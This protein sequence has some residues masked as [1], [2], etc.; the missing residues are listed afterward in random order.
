[1]RKFLTVSCILIA[2]V[3]V[4][5]CSD[6][7]K[8]YPVDTYNLKPGN[9][10]EGEADWYKSA[11]FYHLWV[12]AFNDAKYE[13]GLGDL[14]GIVKKMDYLEDLGVTAIWLSP[15]F[16]CA[17]KKS[18]IHGYDVTD[19]YSLND[20]FGTKEDL[21]DLIDEA[22]D[23]GIRVIFDFPLNHTST[24]HKWM[25]EH[26]EWYVWSKETPEKWGLPWGGGNPYNVWRFHKN[27]SHFYSAFANDEM[28]DLNYMYKD[29]S[30]R[31]PVRDEMIKTAKY[32]LDRGFDGIRV[33]AARYLVEDGPG[34]QADSA[35]TH[36]FFRELRKS[37]DEY[38]AKTKSPK[39][40]IAEAWTDEPKVGPYFGSGRDEFQICFDFMNAQRTV[41]A[42]Q[43]GDPSLL[44]TLW[45]FERDNY[46]DGYTMGL[47]Q[48]NHDN[49]TSR[50]ATQFEGEKE[51]QILSAA[52]TVFGP[53]VPFIY[54]GNE[55]GMEGEMGNDA[56]LRVAIDW[57]EVEK[58]EDDKNSILNWYRRIIKTRN[59]CPSLSGKTHILTVGDDEVLALVKEKGD[60]KT[61]VILNFGTDKKDVSLDLASSGV[62]ENASVYP[63][64]GELPKGAKLKGASLEVNGI[65]GYGI[66]VI[67]L[68]G[69]KPPKPVAGYVK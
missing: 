17:K 12:R 27:Q 47:F 7:K 9:Q 56:N 2:F 45:E 28:A 4:S 37:L 52:V 48:T 38:A 19:F 69:K 20:R 30:G 50:P 67:Y 29:A 36:A 35:E 31:Y 34:K 40:M 60:E 53:G 58:Q 65:P 8:G 24:K 14:K 44:A 1:M 49:V 61:L 6:R 15:I 32:W 26:P 43:Q 62:S 41:S 25:E 3:F 57:K 46:P 59:S 42:I 33:D 63:V 23:H 22:H 68:A 10:L 13:D 66:N 54:Y 16:D 11:V 5:A 55:I 51:A 39:I 21:E 64:L 18:A